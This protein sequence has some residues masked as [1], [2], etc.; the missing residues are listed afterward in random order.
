[1]PKKFLKRFLPDHRTIRDHK[2]LK[3]FGR[4]LHD[5][6][7]WHLNRR[8]VP[9]AFS[10]G[11]VAAFIP[12]PL[13]MVLAAAGAIVFR[14]NL[15]ISVALVWITNPLTMPP[16][17]YLQYKL[18][19]WILREPTLAGVQYPP[20]PPITEFSFTSMME[21]LGHIWEPFLL[22]TVL[23]ALISALTANLIIRAI[24][25]LHI[26][27]YVKRRRERATNTRQD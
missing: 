16:L 18:G 27:R 9:G 23:L 20:T 10:V 25:W 8:S 12:V 21:E 11:L 14:V 13:Q 7:L 3:I 24:W 5:P 4:L 1:M 17:F 19:A 2:H 15:P 26:N 6:N 22:G